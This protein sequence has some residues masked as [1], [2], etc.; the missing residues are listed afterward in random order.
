MK[1]KLK[2]NQKNFQLNQKGIQHKKN[3][4]NKY[5]ISKFK[6]LSTIAKLIL[7]KRAKKSNKISVNLH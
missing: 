5:H 4:T 7:N 2:V 3:L 6:I 1:F